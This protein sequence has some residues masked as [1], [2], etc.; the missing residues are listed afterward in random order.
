MVSSSLTDLQ[1]EAD[2]CVI[3][4]ACELDV[5]DALDTPDRKGK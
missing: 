1:A 3:Y 4:S 2:V 5:V